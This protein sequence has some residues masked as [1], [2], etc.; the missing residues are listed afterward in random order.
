MS[1]RLVPVQYL[2]ILLSQYSL[3]YSLFPTPTSYLL[4]L[5]HILTHSQNSHPRPSPSPRPHP[6]ASVMTNMSTASYTPRHSR[7][8]SPPLSVATPS[9]VGPQTQ[10]LNVVT[11][12]TVEG[13]AKRAEG[14]PIKMYMK[15]CRPLG[16]TPTPLMYLLPSRSLFL[17]TILF[18][19]ARF[20]SSKVGII[21][22][23]QLSPNAHAFRR[24][25]RK[26][27]R[28][29]STPSG[30]VFYPL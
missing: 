5:T 30:P 9:T 17:W 4:H 28:I 10:R 1:T 16:I 19:G 2:F 18:P 12:L 29:R 22:L 21:D 15:V 3:H 24:G 27:P 20:R 6:Y 7:T 25:K 26:D 11:R 8:T 14:V 13:N 23:C